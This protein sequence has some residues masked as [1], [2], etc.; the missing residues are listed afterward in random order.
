MK[1][2][3]LGSILCL[4]ST[5]ACGNTSAPSGGGGAGGGGGEPVGGLMGGFPPSVC[6]VDASCTA[7]DDVACVCNGCDPAGCYSPDASPPIQSDC[8][9]AACADDVSCDGCDENGVCDPFFERCNCI[10]CAGFPT[11]Q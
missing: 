10:D 7:G 5:L 1:R 4:A 3:W 9:C 6:N 2:I 8:T 11:C